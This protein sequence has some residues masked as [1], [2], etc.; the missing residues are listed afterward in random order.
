M[1]EYVFGASAE[2]L[3]GTLPEGEFIQP[4]LDGGYDY[5]PLRK[6][7]GVIYKFACQHKIDPN[8][9]SLFEEFKDDNNIQP[10]LFEE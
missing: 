1:S 4:R 7:G 6:M 3:S 2:W 10:K 9:P 5:K 8:Q